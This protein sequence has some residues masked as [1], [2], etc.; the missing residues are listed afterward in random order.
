MGRRCSAALQWQR[1][2]AVCEDWALSTYKYKTRDD[3]LM[4]A[5]SVGEACRTEQTLGQAACLCENHFLV[6]FSSQPNPRHWG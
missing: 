3:V 2:Q 5:R 6:M 1:S 4:Q